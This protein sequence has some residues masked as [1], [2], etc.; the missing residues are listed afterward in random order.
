MSFVGVEEWREGK[1]RLSLYQG[2][3]MTRNKNF[4]R[5]EAFKFNFSLPVRFQ[6]LP[7]LVGPCIWYIGNC[8]Q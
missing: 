3:K 5:D 7:M 4:L 2:I 8:K 6:M 1:W